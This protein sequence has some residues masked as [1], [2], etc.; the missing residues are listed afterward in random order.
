MTIIRIAER[1]RYTILA[2]ETLRDSR[3]SFRARGIHAFVMSHPD[4]WRIDALSIS[5]EGK[6]GRES[7]RAALGELREFRYLVT[8]R[9]QD[10]RGRFT[11]ES[12][13]Y[14]RPQPETPGATEDG[15]PGVG[16]PGVGSPGAKPLVL[17]GTTETENK[18]ASRARDADREPT[19]E[20]AA[21]A[22]VRAVDLVIEIRFRQ[23]A[24]TNPNGWRAKAVPAI[25]AE[26]FGLFTT[27]AVEHPGCTAYEIIRACT[28]W[29]EVDVWEIDPEAVA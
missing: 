10:A 15:F 17:R 6:E 4:H 14:E 20:P 5:R 18:A 2:S 28:E 21:A 16:S 26:W 9:S 13:M 25:R 23:T 12:V 1:P 29:G 19:A 22:V 3:L 11:T 7:V 27:W 24:P 8:T